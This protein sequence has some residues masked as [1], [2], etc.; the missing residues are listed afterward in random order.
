MATGSS[1][2]PALVSAL[3]AMTAASVVASVAAA[4]VAALVAVSV[5]VSTATFSS[6]RVVPRARALSCA[7][8][9]APACAFARA[10]SGVRRRQSMPRAG[11][12][13]CS[14]ECASSSRVKTCSPTPS[15]TAAAAAAPAHSPPRSR[16]PQRSPPRGSSWRESAQSQQRHPPSPSHSLSSTR[17]SEKSRSAVSRL[18]SPAGRLCSLEPGPLCAALPSGG[19]SPTFTRRHS[20]LRSLEPPPRLPSFLLTSTP[21]VTSL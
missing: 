6:A 4:S 10:P 13:A 17:A 8:A 5:A 15:T 19:C 14:S 11:T 20:L 18:W 1:L 21:P 12:L 9:R 2:I 7:L 3:A 16:A